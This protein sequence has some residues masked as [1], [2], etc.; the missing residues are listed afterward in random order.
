MTRMGRLLWSILLASPMGAVRHR[1]PCYPEVFA[2]GLGL[3]LLE[4]SQVCRTLSLLPFLAL[5]YFFWL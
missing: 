2:P 3:R 5:I 1:L 4:W